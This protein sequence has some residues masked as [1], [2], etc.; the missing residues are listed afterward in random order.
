LGFP[1]AP[2][3]AV[4][5]TTL[6]GV[7]TGVAALR[8]RGVSL[9]VVTLAAALALE[10]LV[11]ASS[12]LG[13]GADGAPVPSPHLFGVVLG[14]DAAFRGLDDRLPSPVFGFT[15][16]AVAVALGLAVARLRCTSLGQRM[17][18]VRANERAAAGAG[19]DV[20]RVKLAAF[21]IS[22]AIAGVAGVL[23]GYNFGSVSATRFGALASVGLVAFAY[24]GG[25]TR[26]SGAVVAG[27]FTTE[28]LV[29]H[30]LEEW[31]GISGRWALLVGGVALVLTVRAH[32]EGIAGTGRSSS[33]RARAT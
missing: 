22:S 30:A 25:I 2:A 11:F 16:L 21:A 14:P 6:L 18:A 19:V 17:L 32:P 31:L 7:L 4:A 13:A 8:V 5:A 33:D 26:V 24:I 29:P 20:A 15:V 12:T 28:A 9:A 10:Q 1:V 27:L 23:Y 3:L